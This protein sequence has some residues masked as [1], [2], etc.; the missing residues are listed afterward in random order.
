MSR[1]RGASSIGALPEAPY[2][3]LTTGVGHQS[4]SVGARKGDA[5]T[6]A[7]LSARPVAGVRTGMAGV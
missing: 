3:N 1:S 6:D 2:R 5:Q 4:S 7:A